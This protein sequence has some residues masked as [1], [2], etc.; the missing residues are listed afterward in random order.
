MVQRKWSEFQSGGASQAGDQLVGLRGGTNR[1]WTIESLASF[2]A[3]SIA[4]SAPAALDT[5]AEIAEALNND[6]N[7]IDTIL[8]AIAA[9]QDGSANLTTLAEVASGAYGRGLLALANVAAFRALLDPLY[10]PKDGGTLTGALGGTT[11]AFDSFS[12]GGN[13][14]VDEL[15]PGTDGAFGG[16]KGARVKAV[17]STNLPAGNNDV[18]TVPAGKRA[19]L[20]SFVGLNGG[21]GATGIQLAV[22]IGGAYYV[23]QNGNSTAV[24]GNSTST[25][26]LILEAGESFAIVTGAAGVNAF[27]RVVEFDNTAPFK[28]VRALNPAAG[29]TVVYTVPNGKTANV[30]ATTL[31]VG[32]AV[33][34]LGIM[35]N[36]GAGRTVIGH[37]TAPGSVATSTATR[38]GSNGSSGLFTATYAPVLGST[39]SLVIN[40]DAAMGGGSV[41]WANIFEF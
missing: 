41:V 17:R 29:D 40:L 37:A 1:R 3:A 33:G 10:L 16:L 2:I 13:R 24:N 31:G 38:V 36:S 18:Y 28:S 27:L 19:A 25:T 35:N 14:V 23:I 15:M 6:P 20:G 7:A 34:L 11:A 26:N 8:T 9:K 12:Q 5:L 39:E 22:K 4:G 30:H 21:A 32:G